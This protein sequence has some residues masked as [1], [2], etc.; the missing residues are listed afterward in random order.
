[1]RSVI[2]I[3]LISF[4]CSG[5]MRYFSAPQPMRGYF[6]K[7]RG[8]NL[9]DTLKIYYSIEFDSVADKPNR[10]KLLKRGQDFY[11]VSN[12]LSKK[13]DSLFNFGFESVSTELVGKNYLENSVQRLGKTNI[14]SNN[15]LM[16]RPLFGHF[17]SKIDTAYALFVDTQGLSLIIEFKFGKDEYTISGAPTLDGYILA[18]VNFLQDNKVLYSRV[19]VTRSFL[20]FRGEQLGTPRAEGICWFTED[21]FRRLAAAIRKDLSQK[22]MR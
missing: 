10:D 15:H 14:I 22:L 20:N 18:D 11:Q 16:P 3:V 4:L 9:N 17:I 6:S 1:M 5:C 13:I 7:Q 8:Y 12:F 19:W 2:F 21:N